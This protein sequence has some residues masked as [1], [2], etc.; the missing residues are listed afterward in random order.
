MLG[1]GVAT[2][3]FIAGGALLFDC[4]FVFAHIYHQT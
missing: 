1:G 3:L 2:S 4:A